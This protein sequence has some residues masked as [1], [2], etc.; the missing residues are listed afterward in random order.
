MADITKAF[1]AAAPSEERSLRPLMPKEANE[2][3]LIQRPPFRLGQI[4]TR[5]AVFINRIFLGDKWFGSGYL[6]V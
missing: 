5:V 2:L 6:A 1:D 4:Q 3:I